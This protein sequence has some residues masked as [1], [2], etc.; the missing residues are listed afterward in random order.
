MSN[1]NNQPFLDYAQYVSDAMRAVV[2]KS[3]EFVEQHGFYDNHHF[4]ISFKTYYDGVILPD[5]L[6]AEYAD[7]MT[8][9]VQHQFYDL[10]V[11]DDYFCVSLSFNKKLHR[12]TIPYDA[13]VSFS[14]PEVNMVLRFLVKNFED[15]S[16]AEQHEFEHTNGS[17][18]LDSDLEFNENPL[19]DKGKRLEFKENLVAD[20]KNKG[21]KKKKK[22][23]ENNI[24]DFSNFRKED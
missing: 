8:I 12:L 16:E 6:L 9:V 10:M 3:L 23:K 17:N 1:K 24:I 2:K 22:G 19:D 7:E 14:D 20:S 21:K 5:F 11:K 18:G 13:I 15:L 4:Y